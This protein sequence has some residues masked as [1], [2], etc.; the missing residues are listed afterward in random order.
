MS[1][2]K[3]LALLN[4][5]NCILAL[6]PIELCVII[7]SNQLAMIVAVLGEPLTMSVAV[8]YNNTISNI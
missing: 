3:Y 7:N 2:P 1:F 6:F 8:G 4:S 5:V